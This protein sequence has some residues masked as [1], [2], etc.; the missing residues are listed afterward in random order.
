MPV[1]RL[2]AAGIQV[3]TVTVEYNRVSY[4]ADAT[5][6]S[7]SLPTLLN[8]VK[9]S[10]LVRHQNFTAFRRG[11]Q[12][13]SR[14]PPCCAVRVSAVW[15]QPPAVVSHDFSSGRVMKL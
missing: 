5:V 15:P 9:S 14:V 1:E 6:G 7:A 8:T 4:E 10:L 2:E 13:N 3:P 11:G 12:D